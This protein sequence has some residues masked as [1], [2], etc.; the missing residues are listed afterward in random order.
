MGFPKVNPH[1][2]FAPL[3]FGD[4][5]VGEVKYA[6][7]IKVGVAARRGAFTTFVLDADIPALLC[8]WPLE[9]LGGQLDSERKIST[10]RNPAAVFP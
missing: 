5:R 10:I 6:A 7:D 4:W 9:A 8:R 2:A 1:P 3:K